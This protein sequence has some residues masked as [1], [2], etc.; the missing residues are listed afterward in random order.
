VPQKVWVNNS[1]L[2]V[3]NDNNSTQG[4]IL[5]KNLCRALTLKLQESTDFYGRITIYSI[6][7][8]GCEEGDIIEDN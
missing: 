4:F 5:D 6:E 8:W 3:L 2:L 7:V 1:Q